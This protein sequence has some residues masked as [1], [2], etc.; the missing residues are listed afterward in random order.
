MIFYPNTF[1]EIDRE[2]VERQAAEIQDPEEQS[3]FRKWQDAI[4]KGREGEKLIYDTLQ[5]INKDWIV[6]HSFRLKS[7]P[8]T[9]NRYYDREIDFL[10][11]IPN[12]GLICLEVKNYSNEH[13]PQDDP[14][15]REPICQADSAKWEVVNWL[16]EVKRINVRNFEH[17]AGALMVG[18]STKEQKDDKAYL[19]S[20]AMCTDSRQLEGFIYS[21]FKTQIGASPMTIKELHD[22]LK[23]SVRYNMSLNDYETI[24]SNAIAPINNI[25]PALSEC[26]YGINVT[27]CAGSG[28]TV[29]ALKEACR[30]AGLGKRVLYLCY[31]KNLA[32]WLRHSR[33]YAELSHKEA[34]RIVH[35]HKFASEFL[36]AN[37]HQDDLDESQV[38]TIQTTL[39]MDESRQYDYVF[40]DEAQDF[41]NNYWRAIKYAPCDGGKLYTFADDEQRLRNTN[42]SVISLP[43]K[44]QL[45][46]NLRNAKEIADYGASM[47]NR[48]D[49]MLSLDLSTQNVEIINPI[50]DAEQRAR[51]VEKIANRLLTD[52]SMPV[53]VSRNQIVVLSPYRE[54]TY[55]HLSPDKF[56]LPQREQSLRE[57][58]QRFERTLFNPDARKV[59]AETVKGFKGLEAGYIILTD[60]PEPS[61]ALESGFTLSD[62]YVACSRAKYGLYIIPMD[63][64]AAEAARIYLPEAQR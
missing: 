13:N 45:A 12:R 23:S 53:P 43:T 16:K 51:Q 59:L 3:R 34:L 15:Y 9:T 29:L 48:P 14:D 37:F 58:E 40:V 24:L 20:R 28:K 63:E 18:A 33:E 38:D 22:I 4:A 52:R 44:V 62:F 26:A 30:L 47:L 31:N 10:V 60:M 25:L 36:L 19:C 46:T 5:K 7:S 27:G 50:V 2:E 54:R 64:A 8:K 49:W 42:A 55:S 61:D 6:F 39:I 32:I 35:F 21:R 1:P 17:T 56:S 57:L 11:L 41:T